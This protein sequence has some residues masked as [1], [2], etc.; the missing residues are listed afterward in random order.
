[1]PV[2]ISWQVNNRI[3]LVTG[4]DEVTFEDLNPVND[5]LLATLKND[6]VHLIVDRRLITKYPLNIIKLKNTLSSLNHPNFGWLLVVDEQDA[7]RDFLIG[8]VTQLMRTPFR[9]M[10]TL[11][12][13]ITFLYQHDKTLSRV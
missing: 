11:D 8:I 5:L 10:E 13:A 7:M 4:F 2:K 3:L 6:T 9:R 12:D 1:M